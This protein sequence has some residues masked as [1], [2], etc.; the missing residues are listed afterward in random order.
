MLSFFV[1]GESTVEDGN[2]FFHRIPGSP[3]GRRWRRKLFPQNPVWFSG[4][5]LSPV[6]RIRG[7][8]RATEPKGIQH[9]FSKG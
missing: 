4:Y 1:I 9:G 5:R 8:R 2:L 6:G 3:R 7:K